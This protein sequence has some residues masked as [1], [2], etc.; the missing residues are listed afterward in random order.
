[1]RDDEHTLDHSLKQGESV[2]ED[3]N[4]LPA[5]G[6]KSEGKMT[7]SKEVKEDTGTI[8]TSLASYDFADLA[9]RDRSNATLKMLARLS[10]LRTVCLFMLVLVAVIVAFVVPASKMGQL[11]SQR[12]SLSGPSS[13]KPSE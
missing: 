5:D 13:T 4:M 7:K 9:R 1:M 3:A 8:L 6:I 12:T 10:S 11:K 2:G